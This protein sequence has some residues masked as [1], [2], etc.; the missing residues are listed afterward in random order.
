MTPYQVGL[1]I[2]GRELGEVGQRGQEVR[3]GVRVDGQAGRIQGV[4]SLLGPVF[5]QR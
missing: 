1:L 2:V 5:I 4:S 3:R